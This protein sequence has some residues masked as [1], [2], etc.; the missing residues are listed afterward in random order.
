M[1]YLWSPQCEPSSSNVGTY[2][3]MSW[4]TWYTQ[5]SHDHFLACSCS[6]DERC[7]LDWICSFLTTSWLSSIIANWCLPVE[8]VWSVMS[9]CMWSHELTNIPHK[10]TGIIF[11]III[12]II[13]MVTI[14]MSNDWITV[15]WIICHIWRCCKMIGCYYYLFISYVV[16]F[17]GFQFS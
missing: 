9:Y 4:I 6:A 2:G 14:N 12:V 8:Q 7:D 17:Y 10:V 5:G 16:I 3:N 15:V 13:T 11:V 1:Q